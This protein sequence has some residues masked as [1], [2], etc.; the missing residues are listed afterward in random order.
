MK[1]IG[2]ILWLL[3]GGFESALEYFAVSVALFCTIIGIPFALQTFKIGLLMLWP[4]GSRIGA[5]DMNGC[6]ATVMNVIW[7]IF[8][9]F[10]IFLTHIF[11]GLL[12]YITII[13]I[14]FGNAHF[15]LAGLAVAPF[16]KEIDLNTEV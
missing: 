8:G 15:K 12:L 1:I 5:G 11:F 7:F 9:G 16:G 6:L 14:P 13:G 2:N 10:L 4:F 3:L